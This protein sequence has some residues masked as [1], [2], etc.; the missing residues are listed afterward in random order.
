MAFGRVLR[1]AR[2]RRGV[3]GSSTFGLAQHAP[4]EQH[5][6]QQWRKSLGE[7]H[8]LL[9]LEAKPLRHG[10]A[11]PEGPAGGR[12]ADITALNAKCISADTVATTAATSAGKTAPKVKAM[13]TTKPK[14][15]ST[16]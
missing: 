8:Q 6:Y 14:M 2:D 13:P 10:Q 11:D 15:Y 1:P 12:I 9:E 3:T 7:K 16:R 4:P 5:D